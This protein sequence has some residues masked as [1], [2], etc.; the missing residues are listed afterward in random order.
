MGNS[1]QLYV[2]PERTVALQDPITGSYKPF[3]FTSKQLEVVNIH[4]VI[5]GD[6]SQ[7]VDFT[8]RFGSSIISATGGTEIIE[9][10]STTT[11]NTDG[12]DFNGATLDNT[13]IA[14]DD[15]IWVLTTSVSGTVRGFIVTLTFA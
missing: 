12:D 6:T 8:V 10:G 3:H 5:E 14:A 15:F 7:D 11:N 13:T 9:L 2:E 4:A 1:I